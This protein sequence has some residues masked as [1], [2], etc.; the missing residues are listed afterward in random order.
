MQIFFS[1][2]K[3]TNL[4]LIKS[5]S[6]I[7]FCKIAEGKADIYP[8]LHSIK[9]W[10]IAAGDAILRA[11]GGIIIDNKMADYNYKTLTVESGIFFAV[12]SKRKWMNIIKPLLT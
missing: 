5:S 3:I 7:K 8:R 12:S 2:P 6:S 1:P 9:K 4:E 10:D 11:A